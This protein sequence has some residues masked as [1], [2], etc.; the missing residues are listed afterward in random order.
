MR[1][2]ADHEAGVTLVETLVA[3][4]IIGLAFTAIVGGMR[5]SIMASD[6]NRKQAGATTYLRSY[7]EAV[8][9][10]A[11]VNCAATYAGA[12]FVLP[13][14]SGFTKDAPVVAYWSS[15]TSTF[16]VGCGA[17]SGIQRVTLGIR[18]A[19]GRVAETLQIVKRTP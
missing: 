9:G 7:A 16:N 15:V 1:P 2:P 17:D 10:D 6:I 19:D 12:G 13:G 4:A 8:N 18:S 3:V 5:T 11:Y 14:A